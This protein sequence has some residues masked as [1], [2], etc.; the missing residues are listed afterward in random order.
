MAREKFYASCSRQTNKSLQP[1]TEDLV[2]I[3]SKVFEEDSY[4]GVGKRMRES[5]IP[6][7]QLEKNSS[8]I[9]GSAQKYQDEYQGEDIVVKWDT[10]QLKDMVEEPAKKEI[11][12]NNIKLQQK[13]QYGSSK[14]NMQLVTQIKGIGKEKPRHTKRRA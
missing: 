7:V 9:K 14:K 13:K 3:I 2:E 11:Q 1:I 6:A 4:E 10:G 12:N 5:K 8:N